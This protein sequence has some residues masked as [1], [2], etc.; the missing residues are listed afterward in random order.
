MSKSDTLTIAAAQPPS[1][2]ELAAATQA[3]ATTQTTVATV[4]QAPAKGKGG[5]SA[6]PTFGELLE[7]QFTGLLVVFVVLGGLTLVCNLIAQTLKI[8]APRHYDGSVD[9][10]AAAPPVPVAAAT[11][12]AATPV[13]AAKT[14]HPGL[15]DDRLLAILTV[16]VEH[17]LGQSAAVVKFRHMGS[18]DWTWSVQGRVGIHNSHNIST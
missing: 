8:I 6:A 11:P 2:A 10:A 4:V 1:A 16:A 7:F 9:A 15:S 17:V 14:V 5:F 3:P 13:A 18:M 12:V